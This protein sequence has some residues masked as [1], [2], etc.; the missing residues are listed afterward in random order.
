MILIEPSIQ[1]ENLIIKIP[2]DPPEEFS[3]PLFPSQA[4]LDDLELVEDITLFS[5]TVDG[6]AVS[7]EIDEA[8]SVYLG[9]GVRLVVKGPKIRLAGPHEPDGPLEYPAELAGMYQFAIQGR[10]LIDGQEQ[11]I[12]TNILSSLLHLLRSRKPK[13]HVDRASDCS[14]SI[15]TNRA[16]LEAQ[17][18]RRNSLPNQ[19]SRSDFQRRKFCYREMEAQYSR[20]WNQGRFWRRCLGAG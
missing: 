2:N 11:I 1:G 3:T 9:T 12:T 13:K 14:V 19:R 7:S 4:E 6:Y 20:F 10:Q 15:L 17:V 16:V 8:L 18:D 5:D